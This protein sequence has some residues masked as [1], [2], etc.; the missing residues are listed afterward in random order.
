MNGNSHRNGGCGWNL[1]LDKICVEVGGIAVG[2][3]RLMEGV[4]RGAELGGM[5]RG[6]GE[7][8]EDP[9]REVKGE[10]PVKRHN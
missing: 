6:Q 1:R 4:G 9:M 10:R 3:A 7:E 2:I 5:F 8:K